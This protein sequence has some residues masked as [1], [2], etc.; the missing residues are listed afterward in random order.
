[1]ALWDRATGA[2]YLRPM[3]P[4]PR[5]VWMPG[6]VRT[7][8]HLGA[9]E[10]GGAFCLLV[11]H[12]PAGWRL[13]PHLHRGTAETIHVLEGQFEMSVDGRPCRLS[14]GQTL[15]IP[16]DLVHAGGNVG[17]ATGRRVLIFSPAGMENFF[18]EAGAPSPEDEVD[19]RAAFASAVRHG[20]E[21]V[22]D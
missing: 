5:T 13:P 16:A 17:A 7:D 3:L 8:M 2:R 21:F 6:R 15:H 11:D 20:W 10:T 14:A 18:L 9:D 4:E 1:M 22:A 12:P 19:P